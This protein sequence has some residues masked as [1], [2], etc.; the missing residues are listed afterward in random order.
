M[1]SIV[2]IGMDVHKATYSLCALDKST[3]AILTETQCASEPKLVKKFI[4]G[5]AK[6]LDPDTEFVT[7][8]EAGILGYSLYRSLQALGI[9][10]IIMAPTT[11]FSSAK[12]KM[13]KND[14]M[15]ARMIAKNLAANTYRA[16]YVPDEADNDVKEFIRLRKSVR[17]QLTR[18]KQQISMFILRQG[19]KCSAS[20]WSLPYNAWL[21]KVSLRPTLRLILDELLLQKSEL[22]EKLARY[23]QEIE[24]F[25]NSERYTKPVHALVCMKGIQTTSAMTIHVEIADFKRFQSARAFMSYVGLNPSEHSSGAHTIKGG[26]SKQGNSIVRTTII[27][28]THGLVKGKLGYK[29]KDLKKRQAGQDAAVISYVDK[30]AVHLQRKFNRMI[31]QG[32]EYNVAIAAVARELAGFIWG[33]ETN[34]IEY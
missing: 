14:S 27:E 18:L 28:A 31:T 7:G 10:C 15:D 19:L 25:S 26:I 32:K 24:I 29:S 20:K 22:E 13:V 6:D 9:D 21:R 3:G 8:Y 12:N 30:A 11:M 1:Q 5:L 33:L 4:V 2:Y 23:D 16:V 17:K 34:N